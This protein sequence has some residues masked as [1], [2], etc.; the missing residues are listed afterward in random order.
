[1][2]RF[3][4]LLGLRDFGYHMRVMERKDQLDLI[5]R[6]ASVVGH[7]LRNPLAVINNSAYFLK[8]KLAS[9]GDLDPK[10]AKHL[11]I[12]NSAIARLDGM[13][14]DILNYSRPLSLKT[15]PGDLNACVTAALEAFP[16]LEGIK[17]AK[18]LGPAA[19]VPIEPAALAD[20][21]RRV[22]IN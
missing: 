16:A 14:A 18:K 20:A 5:R 17:V 19:K 6:I 1:G 9:Q 7:E 22:L 3:A 21:L 2:P 4:G 15:A 10:V 8:S 13:I 11:D 12:V